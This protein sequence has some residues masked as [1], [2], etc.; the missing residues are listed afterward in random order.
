LTSEWVAKNEA[1]AEAARTAIDTASRIAKEDAL[2]VAG[3]RR[4]LESI[5]HDLKLAAAQRRAERMF[6][7]MAQ[8][9]ENLER[10]GHRSIEL[11]EH[12]QSAKPLNE[13]WL[14]RYA[15]YAQ[16]VSDGDVQELWAR[17]L[18]SAAIADKPT[19][20]HRHFF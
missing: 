9:Q 14:L 6:R 2:V 13:D 19:S 20:H 15:D 4:Q 1:R 5:G 18:K 11:I 8:E 7:Q 10:I 3:R 16:Q 17:I 12:D